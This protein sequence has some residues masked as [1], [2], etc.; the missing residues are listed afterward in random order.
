MLRSKMDKAV[1]EVA[2]LNP[3]QMAVAQFDAAEK[4][5]LSEDLRQVLRYPKRELIVNFPVRMA[6][7]CDPDEKIRRTI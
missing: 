4:L 3:Y 1:P 6:C 2:S 5:N 7:Q